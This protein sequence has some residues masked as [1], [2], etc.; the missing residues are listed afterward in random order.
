MC[1]YKLLYKI[2]NMDYNSNQPEFYY[3]LG[4]EI[5]PEGIFER[6]PE[7]I[8]A[9]GDH[10]WREDNK[11]KKM[12]LVGESNYFGDYP[13]TVSVFKDADKWYT[14]DTDKLIPEEMKTAVGNWIDY[15]TFNKVFGIMDR[16][17]SE[18]GIE[19]EEKL[20]E[21]AFYNYFLRP[22]FN[23]G[24][25]KGFRPQSI[26]REISGIALSGIID[27][28]KP[29]LIIFLSKKAYVEFTAYCARKG[30]E[31]A[32]ITIAHV[33]HPSSAWWNRYGGSLGKKK[34]EDLIKANWIK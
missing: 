24:K 7:L 2:D 29:D 6:F 32:G 30:K 28:I 23:D 10:Y 20:A 34:F 25:N 1:G 27:K 5:V 13:E 19:H 15:R 26:D 11:H 22:A 33:A 3:G 12:L 21:I 14:A 16:V 4:K 18:A 8:P 9:V 31:Y 17:L